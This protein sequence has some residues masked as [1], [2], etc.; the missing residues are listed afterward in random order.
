LE[1]EEGYQEIPS[2]VIS[3]V[4]DSTFAHT[5]Q[6]GEKTRGRPL[7]ERM[8]SEVYNVR[9]HVA[10]LEWCSREEEEEI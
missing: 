1:E 4:N 10:Q 5:K 7:N 3:F 6:R 8:S 9:G 2:R